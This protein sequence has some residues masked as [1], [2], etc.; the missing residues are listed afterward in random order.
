M[1]L[2]ISD[3][4]LRDNCTLPPEKKSP[5]LKVEVL[6][7]PPFSNLVG[8]SIPSPA[9]RGGGG[10]HYVALTEVTNWDLTHKVITYSTPRTLEFKSCLYFLCDL[11]HPLKFDWQM[12][13]QAEETGRPKERHVGGSN[14][15][16]TSYIILPNINKLC[17]WTWNLTNIKKSC[18]TTTMTSLGF[19]TVKIAPRKWGY[20]DQIIFNANK[21]VFES[22]F[23][24][25]Q[26]P[27]ILSHINCTQALDIVNLNC[28][29]WS[30]VLGCFCFWLFC[31][32]KWTVFERKNEVTYLKAFS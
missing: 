8:G 7:S 12:G 3:I 26:A 5:P 11:N 6:S 2:N 4:N 17:I 21:M 22:L 13:R 29:F 31:L 1:S 24:F 23:C 9:E 28:N 18:N 15:F 20:F 19:I 14:T 32:L 16:E 27:T 25:S 30:L 10:A